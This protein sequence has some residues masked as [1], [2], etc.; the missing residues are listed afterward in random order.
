M[1]GQQPHGLGSS[2]QCPYDKCYVLV[3]L[4][5][6]C[7]VLMLL[8]LEEWIISSTTILTNS[9]YDYWPNT[10]EG[11][12]DIYMVMAVTLFLKLE[13]FWGLSAIE[14]LL[15]PLKLMLKGVMLFKGLN[16]CM[17]LKMWPNQYLNNKD[18]IQRLWWALHVVKIGE[19]RNACRILLGKPVRKRPLRK[20]RKWMIDSS[21]DIRGVGWNDEK[22]MELDQDHV[23]WWALVLTVL[24]LWVLLSEW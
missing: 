15:V 18:H 14:D 23:K 21:F 22:W 9:M 10:N 1:F 24:I 16:L 2:P 6:D 4:L 19:T 12:S 8:C 5:F 20:L 17:Y 7:T 3:P 13:R 11:R